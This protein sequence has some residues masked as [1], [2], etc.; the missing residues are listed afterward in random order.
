MPKK[1]N[2]YQERYGSFEIGIKFL[3]GRFCLLLFTVSSFFSVSCKLKK[4]S[5][6]Q[7][8]E[9]HFRRCFIFTKANLEGKGVKPF[10][11]KITLNKII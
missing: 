10:G 2:V 6:A 1:V 8:C 11:N 4:F 5:T 7:K 9:F 3:S